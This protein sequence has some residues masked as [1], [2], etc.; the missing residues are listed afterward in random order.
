MPKSTKRIIIS[1]SSLNEYGFRIL[2]D[3][4]DLKQFKKNPLCLYM[5]FR[6][7][8]GTKDELLPLGHWEDI[9]VNGDEISGIPFFDDKDDFAMSIFN[10]VEAGHIRMASGGFRKL[11][12]SEDPKYLL[13]G[14]TSPTAVKS[15]LKEASICDIGGNNNALALYDDNDDI[16]KLNDKNFSN[17]IPLLKNNT[18]E[19]K[20]FL[21]ALNLA[22]TATPDTALAEV[23]KMCAENAQ[24]KT[25]KA[26]L[27][28]EKTTLTAK[29]VDLTASKETGELEVVLSEAVAAGKITE[30]LKPKFAEMGKSNLANLK[31]V[32]EAMPAYKHIKDLVGGNETGN[33]A[34]LAEYAKLSWDQLD[35]KDGALAFLKEND[36]DAFAAKRKEKFP[37]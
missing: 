32:L 29:V 3:G 28:T 37:D 21:K 4:V 31:E 17:H 27:E 1:D 20:D 13:A 6:P 25:D 11:T 24:L 12:W 22:D 8:K 26:N 2:T 10:K 7:W 19:L 36:P 33:A 34:K 18:M 30:A 23:V 9:E 14:Q 16:I 5:H 15:I 35:E